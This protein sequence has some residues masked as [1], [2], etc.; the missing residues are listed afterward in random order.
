[1]PGYLRLDG[2]RKLVGEA[3]IVRVFC[4]AD[5]GLEAKAWLAVVSVTRV[6]ARGFESHLTFQKGEV[7][8]GD[9]G[10][11]VKMFDLLPRRAYFA[12]TVHEGRKARH[13]FAVDETGEVIFCANDD[14]MA[15]I[16][17]GWEG[18]DFAAERAKALLAE[19]QV[20][21]EDPLPEL[22]GTEKQVEWAKR[23]RREFLTRVPRYR[24]AA[25]RRLDARW[26]IDSREE[27]RKL[28]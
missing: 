16:A 18:K 23:I 26:W 28:K 19:Q 21:A 6:L 9:S 17:M 8:E 20:E 11:G 3:P 12:G 24:E 22:A 1:V 14:V 25:T 7:V 5:V 2:E 15:E 4:R 13:P 27:L 10:T